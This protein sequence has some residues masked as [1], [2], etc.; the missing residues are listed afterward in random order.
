MTTMS[1]KLS[2]DKV[3]GLILTV[4]IICF[5][6]AAGYQ[7]GVQGFQINVNQGYKVQIDRETPPDKN[8]DF[9]LFWQVWDT[10]GDK[11]YD[12]S[13]LDPKQ[14]VYGAISGMVSSLGDP[15]TSFLPPTQNKQV[16]EDLSGSFEGVGIQLGTDSSLRLMVDAPLPG[17][18]AEGA[19]VKAGDYITHIKD[20]KKNV[21][22]D[23]G[24]MSITDA[25][26]VI[27][28][29]AGTVVTLTLFRKGVD[30]PVLVDLTRA[31]LDVPSV[32]LKFVGDGENIAHIKLNSFDAESPD[33]WSRAVD[34]V[35]KKGGVK[36]IIIDLRNNPGGYL[37]DSVDLASDFLKVGSV[38][39]TEQAG[40]G[41]KSDYKTTRQ[42]K[43]LNTPVVVLING[44][45]ASAS[46][47]LAGAL[48]DHL[49][50]KL[51]GEKS[52]GKG[53]VQAPIDFPGGAGLH[54]TVAKWLT[55]KGTWVHEVGLT[56]DIEIEMKEATNDAQLQKAI[57][58][59]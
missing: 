27:R 24:G 18:P 40:N 52:F 56:P 25:V 8:V 16:N 30:K 34:E 10:L 58:Q 37:Q 14:M 54:V 19:G 33:E 5:A 17:S 11:Y 59:F 46:E 43:L 49:G 48:R 29:P 21:D 22:K 35:L 32:A 7:F 38:V 53:T 28:G 23:T 20:T 6:F 42:G 26:S 9:S 12:K 57:E 2:F 45:S 31:K 51:I 4:F 39:V 44:G 1:F 55:P 50:A 13:K 3:R 47:I 41:D 36:G 15:F